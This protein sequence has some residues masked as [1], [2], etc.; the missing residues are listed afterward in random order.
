[1]LKGETNMRKLFA[2][3]LSFVILCNIAAPVSAYFFDPSLFEIKSNTYTDKASGT[4]FDLPSGWSAAVSKIDDTLLEFTPAG[5]DSSVAMLYYHEDFWSELSASARSKT[6][7]S[8][9]NNDSYTGNE[10]AKIIGVTSGTWEMVELNKKEYFL[11]KTTNSTKNGRYTFTTDVHHWVLI[12]NGHMFLYTFTGKTSGDVYDDF[13]ELITN[14]QYSTS[15]SKTS[16]STTN[17]NETTYKDAVKAYNRGDYKTA[18]KKFNSVK[19]Y[20]QSE[21][22]LRLIRI[23]N[24][25]S[26]TRIGT[27]FRA[28]YHLTDS[29]KKDIDKAAKNFSFADT[30]DVLVCNSDVAAYYLLGR[31]SVGGGEITYLQ[32]N[33]DIYGSGGYYY[34]RSENLS[35]AAGDTV[36]II[37]GCVTVNV[38]YNCNPTFQITLTDANTMQLYCYEYDRCVTLYRN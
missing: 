2:V 35:K 25:G 24:A 38:D 32:F 23:R 12:E 26:N 28:D 3:L 5:K 7:R 36:S 21:D 13:V 30:A 11:I 16:T 33:K 17:T 14:A 8:K 31:W 29:E 37:N 10:I 34:T 20:S 15:D 4:T 18:E 27:G 1:M 6:S 22:Y 19:S 9:Y